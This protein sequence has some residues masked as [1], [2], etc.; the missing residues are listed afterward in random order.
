M[1]TVDEKANNVPQEDAAHE[2]GASP[3]NN[4]ED[5]DSSHAG[6]YILL[7]FIAGFV[8]AMV[9][10]WVLFPKLLYSKK[11]QPFDFNHALHME[12][13]GEGC[14]SCHYFREDGSFSGVPTLENCIDCHEEVLGDSEDEAIF[15]EQYVAN[16][17]EVPW[18]IYS[19][20]PDCVFFSHAAH[21]HGANMD[22]V[23]CHGHIGESESLK[24]YEQNRISGYSRDI[25][26]QNI[27]GFKRNTWD[28]MKMNDCAACHK[29]AGVHESSVQTRKDACF[30]CHK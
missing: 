10:G 16:E 30:V 25:W 15:V 11:N 12:E 17:R 29:E 23:T 24:P 27:A 13:V 14:E 21:I 18:L 22:C 4:P 19:Q 20:Q 8:A 1:S 5:H 9:V 26:G 2:A 28:R 6:G 7:F 3:P